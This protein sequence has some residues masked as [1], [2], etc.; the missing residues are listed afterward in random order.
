MSALPRPDFT[1]PDQARKLFRQAMSHLGAAVNVITTMGAHGRCGIT[2][3]AVC[4][5][6]DSPPT[7]LVCI[8]R[9][10]AMHA[11]FAG[12]RNVCVNV[13]PGHLEQIARHFAGLTPLSM[14]ERF[15]LPVWDAGTNG[16]PVLRDALA[17]LQ[18]TIVEAKEV[19]SHSVMFVETH[20]IR[21]RDDGDSLI[22][23]DRNFHRVPRGC[24]SQ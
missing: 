24:A 15:S 5:V 14:D 23:F 16:V 17:S 19:G 18:G 6:T 8:N 13:L 10:S 2:A 21:V 3:S 9:S 11:A 22:Y 1:D 4:S 20:D 12:N 7:L